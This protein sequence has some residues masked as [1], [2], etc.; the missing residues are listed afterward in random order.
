[1]TLKRR[2][3]RFLVVL[4]CSC[5]AGCGAANVPTHITSDPPSALILFN[6]KE[7][8]KT[9]LQ[10]TVQQQMGDFNAYTFRA[11]LE[12]Y[13]P[14]V[15]IFKEVSFSDTAS[16]VIPENIHFVLQKVPPKKAE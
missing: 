1:M 6:G 10:T 16:K 13:Q 12:G 11:E 5:L 8:G 9:P 2:I 15:R 4:F 3:I 14:G 7:L